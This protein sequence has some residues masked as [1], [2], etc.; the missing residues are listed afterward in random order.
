[1]PQISPLCFAVTL[2]LVMAI[3]P[4]L[5]MYQLFD[6]PLGRRFELADP[7]EEAPKATT[8]LR[9]PRAQINFIEAIAKLSVSKVNAALS[10]GADPNEGSAGEGCPLSMIASIKDK[11]LFEEVNQVAKVLL[12]HDDI[13]P[14]GDSTSWSPLKNALASGNVGLVKLLLGHSHI[15][16]EV[17]VSGLSCD[18]VGNKGVKFY[19]SPKSKQIPKCFTD[20]PKDRL[21]PHDASLLAKRSKEGYKKP[22]RKPTPPTQIKKPTLDLRNAFITLPTNVYPSREDIV[23]NPT[24]FSNIYTATLYYFFG[25]PPSLPIVAFGVA[26]LAGCLVLATMTLLKVR[27]LERQR[28]LLEKEVAEH[29]REKE[30]VVAQADAVVAPRHLDLEEERAAAQHNEELMRADDGN[31]D[32]FFA[33]A[34]PAEN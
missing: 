4:R 21:V 33:V 6:A 11:S 26:L 13:D 28:A 17:E 15:I 12:H 1:M 20:L 9:T 10:E 30:P 25:L 31:D 2:V 27:Q 5:V 8:P 7:S 34:A 22:T 23:M 16:P 32:A 24:P 29:R 19:I 18:T 3:V 14:N